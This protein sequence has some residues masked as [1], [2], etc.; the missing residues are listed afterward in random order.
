MNKERF[1]RVGYEHLEQDLNT[2]PALS[3]LALCLRMFYFVNI[4]VQE[5]LF[6]KSLNHRQCR[7]AN[8]RRISQRITRK[9]TEVTQTRVKTRLFIGILWL[10]MRTTFGSWKKCGHECF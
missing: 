6:Q 9:V 3:H 10:L 4:F 5:A 8:L 1:R 2:I 7:I